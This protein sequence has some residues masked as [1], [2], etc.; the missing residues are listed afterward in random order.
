LYNAHQD[1]C[2][3]DLPPIKRGRDL[4][5]AQA[6]VLE[7][8]AKGSITPDEGSAVATVLDAHRRA[9]ELAEL[10]ERVG[11]LEVRFGKARR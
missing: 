6:T 4:V 1:A 2:V 11:S 10:V 5:T 7:A 3:S 9:T 8:I